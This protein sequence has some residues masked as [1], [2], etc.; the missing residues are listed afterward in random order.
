MK[1]FKK[2]TVFFLKTTLNIFVLTAGLLLCMG[3]PSYALTLDFED[4]TAGT[5]YSLGDSFLTGGVQAS[6]QDFQWLTTPPRWACADAGFCSGFTEVDTSQLA[7]GSGNDMHFNNASLDF[8]LGVPVTGLS[9]LFGEYGGNVNVDINGALQNF[10]NFADINGATIG[11]VTAS[12]VNGFGNDMG[13]LVFAGSITSFTIG[14][15]E[16]WIDDI[17]FTTAAVPEP[18]S[19][20]LVCAGLVGLGFMRKRFRV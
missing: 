15:Q 17:D 9:L 8:N 6:V 5:T 4:L 7:G 11:G 14:G 3:N 1:R 2:T 13:N 10:Q 12:V 20:L 16:L 18:A 19:L